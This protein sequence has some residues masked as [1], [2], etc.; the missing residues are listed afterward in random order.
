MD[1]Y[2]MWVAGQG[3]PKKIHD[4]LESARQAIQAYKSQGGTREAFILKPIERVEG[5]KLL[6]IKPKITVEPRAVKQ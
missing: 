1:F 6:T 5:R 3:A 4:S 2:L